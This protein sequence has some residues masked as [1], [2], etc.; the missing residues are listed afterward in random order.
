MIRLFPIAGCLLFVLQLNVLA[1]SPG[2][3]S[4]ELFEK[5][6]RP[7]LVA[8]CFK[9]HTSKAKGGLRLDGRGRM[10][11]GGES[12]PA[13]VAGK[14]GASLLIDAIHYGGDSNQMPPDGKLPEAVIG[15]FERWIESGAPWPGDETPALRGKKTDFSI[16]DEQ[17][18]FW[19]FQP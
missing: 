9:C 16:T 6:I 2:I 3:E 13:I 10:L 4:L 12:G 19:A 1:E 7:V 14:P 11:Q 18:A 15:D 17:R 5:K 8:R